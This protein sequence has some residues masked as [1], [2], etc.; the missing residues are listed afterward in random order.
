MLRLG[1][2][3]RRLSG[4]EFQVDR[5]AAAKHWRPNLCADYGPRVP[6]CGLHSNSL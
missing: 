6:E 4:S 2:G 3:W 1:A 5:P